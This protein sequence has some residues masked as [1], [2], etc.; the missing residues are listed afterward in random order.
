MD[1]KKNIYIY[2]IRSAAFINTNNVSISHKLGLKML[3]PNKP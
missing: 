3:K 1:L 2:N